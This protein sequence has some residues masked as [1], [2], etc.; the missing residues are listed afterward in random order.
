MAIN[1]EVI[2]QVTQVDVLQDTT[3]VDVVTAGVQGV[4]GLAGVPVTSF[5]TTPTWR[6][7]RGQANGSIGSNVGGQMYLSPITLSTAV[8]LTGLATNVWTQGTGTSTVNIVLY[9]DTGSFAPGT[10]LASTG[11]ITATTTG[12]KAN[13]FAGVLLQPGIYWTGVLTKSTATVPALQLAQQIQDSWAT[14]NQGTGSSPAFAQGNDGTTQ[15][16]ASG[17]VTPPATFAGTSYT[18]SNS[19]KVPVWVTLRLNR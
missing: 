7:P 10:L 15:G 9:S 11:D 2:Q 8:T 14:M 13:L 4:P 19:P 6:A 3:N 18:D 1:V 12:A 16:Y 17:L 5:S